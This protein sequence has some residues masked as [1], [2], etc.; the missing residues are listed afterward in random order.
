MASMTARALNIGPEKVLVFSTGAI[1]EKLDVKK[2]GNGIRE[3]A[4]TL[5]SDKLEQ[6]ADSICT[7][8]THRKVSSHS[9]SVGQKKINVLGVAKGAGMI[10]PRMATM[11]CFILTDAKIEG[12][13]LGTALRQAVDD[14]FNCITVDGD[15]STNDSVI[16]LANGAAGN[17]KIT[18]NSKGFRRFSKSLNYICQDLA[19]MI[20]KDGEGASKF[21]TV[22]VKGATGMRA[23]RQV[24]KS[25]ANSNLV[26]TAILGEDSSIWGRIAAA[27]GYSGVQV[28]AEK[29]V[30]SLGGKTVLRKN[31]AAN[32]SDRLLAK[33][34]SGKAVEIEVNLCMG[35][36]NATVWTCDLT[37]DYVKFNAAYHT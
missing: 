27:I 13:A 25:I 9:F 31:Q 37:C 18:L 11:L 35:K 21:V 10:N 7:T 1:G 5:S 4:K 16:L 14:S 6:F 32:Y 8:D 33:H 29:V 2:I 3:A 28:N 19:K 30:I 17:K 20:A 15:T 26:K 23:A 24:A 22:K 34:L 12:R 36:A